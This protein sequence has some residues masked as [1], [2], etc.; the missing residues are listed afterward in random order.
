VSADRVRD[1][2]QILDRIEQD[3]WW[4]VALRE[5]IVETVSA[6]VPA[7]SRVLDVGCSTGHVI[8]GIPSE[9]ERTGADIS[10]GAIELARATRP[11]I[12]FVE[13]PVEDLPFEDGSFD[14]VLAL[15]VL[16]A[17]GVDDEGL[18]LREIGRVLRPEGVLV[19]QV[20]AYEWL[21]SAYD[22]SAGTARRHTRRSVQELLRSEGFLIEHLTYRITALFPLAAARRL[23]TRSGGAN[24][25]SVPNPTL[26]R[27]LTGATRFENR[28]VR[29]HRLP[30][31]LSVFAVA[32]LEDGGGRGLAG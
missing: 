5:L 15:D 14:C 2:H 4:F 32:A 19:V 21:R 9:Y 17:R 11:E 6:R 13:A 28:F 31:G 29:R 26:N 20:A 24:D 10:A 30:F 8:A 16:S 1:Y 3:H 7:G 27:L 23:L 25:L 12:R 18:A 22:D